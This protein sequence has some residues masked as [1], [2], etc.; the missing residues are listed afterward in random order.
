[1]PQRNRYS[2]TKEGVATF[3][4]RYAN[5][6][7]FGIKNFYLN[8]GFTGQLNNFQAYVNSAGY[9]HVDVNTCSTSN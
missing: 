9:G 7:G 3:F 8:T 4:R 2:A 6:G 1:M 5:D